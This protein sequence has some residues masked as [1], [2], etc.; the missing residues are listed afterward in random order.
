M[1][2]CASVEPQRVTAVAQRLQEI[3]P[4]WQLLP[5]SSTP[6]VAVLGHQGYSIVLRRS[7]QESPFEEQ[8]QWPGPAPRRAANAKPA[9]RV[10]KSEHIE[11]ILL[12]G[13]VTEPL[14]VRD[15]IPWQDLPQVHFVRPVYAG[16]GQGFAWFCR[17]DIWNQARLFQELGL[18]RGE[19]H[20]GVFASALTVHDYGSYTG[21]TSAGLLAEAG[22][23]GL[24]YIVRV[25]EEHSDDPQFAM[26]A[27]AHN[28]SE[29]STQLLL[30]Y[31]DSD[32][33]AVS[34]QA[35]Y[36]LVH[37]HNGYRASAKEA[38]LEMLRRHEYADY[39]AEACVQFGLTKAIPF[40]QET[41]AKP[42][43]WRSYRVAYE[44]RRALEGNPI[45]QE[46]KA[47]EETIRHAAFQPVASV[48]VAKVR[49]AKDVL[50]SAQDHEAAIVIATELGITRTKARD[51]WLRETGLEILQQLP[52]PLAYE[53]VRQMANA[54]QGQNQHP[55]LA[56][57]EEALAPQ[58]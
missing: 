38:Y 34:H 18:K 29:A 52:K 43:R 11:R 1:S 30:Q 57:L 58:Q 35:A 8:Q 53:F 44:A 22:D 14:K 32:E 5:V 16:T 45:P 17:C 56:R 54:I 7:W 40:L 49:Q 39:A 33:R 50:I 41:C 26:E 37:K 46:L 47:A 42:E 13:A 6:N 9:Q 12:P 4:K 2:G 10:T 24:P 20:L 51:Q 19:D 15:A 48:D 31:F 36:A 23:R 3:F 21:H 25:I 55:E 28:R 27:L